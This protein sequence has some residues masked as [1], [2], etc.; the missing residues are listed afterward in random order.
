MAG[1]DKV[2]KRIFSTKLQ[3]KITKRI[4]VD[5]ISAV[6]VIRGLM[7]KNMATSLLL[8]LPQLS[9]TCCFILCRNNILQLTTLCPLP[10]SQKSFRQK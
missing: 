7:F 1:H 4:R 2:E 8:K 9:Y 5:I 10:K 3:T 6:A